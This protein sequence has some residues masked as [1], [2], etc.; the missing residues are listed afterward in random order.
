MRK[1]FSLFV[2]LGLCGVNPLF[3]LNAETKLSADDKALLFG[4]TEVNI[5][6]LSDEEMEKTKGEGWLAYLGTSAL[7]YGIGWG[8]CKLGGGKDCS[9]K[10]E[11]EFPF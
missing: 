6:T 3:G 1:I 11:T 8:M 2:I 7:V 10:V 5:V 4:N 9:F